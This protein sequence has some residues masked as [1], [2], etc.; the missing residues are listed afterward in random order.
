MKKREYGDFV[1][2]I[3]DCVNHVER[4]TE[5]ISFGTF[6]K[7]AKTIYA[8][9]RAIEIIGEATR[10]IP[11]SIKEKH[12]EVPWRKMA[13][14]RNKLIHEYFGID[15]EILWEVAKREVPKLKTNVQRV[16]EE[17]EK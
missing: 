6:I 1:Q 8:V 9:V 11:K 16:L 14:M 2:D 12:P 3:L 4:F 15:L 10:N 13:G 7:D 5:G 17:M